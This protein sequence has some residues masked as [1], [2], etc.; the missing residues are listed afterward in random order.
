MRA[1]KFRK[2][3]SASVSACGVKAA[4]AKI[5]AASAAAKARNGAVPVMNLTYSNAECFL[6][7][8]YAGEWIDKLD[9]IKS[10]ID[11]RSV[12][13]N[14]GAY[15]LGRKTDELIVAAL[16]GATQE[17]VGTGVG[18]AD[19]DGLTKQKVLMAFEMLGAAD[20]P[21]DGQRFAVVG[22]KQW[23]ELLQIQE[24]AST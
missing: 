7:D 5:F 14:A 17:A 3:T 15:A 4:C 13:A 2:E 6:Q 19:T 1:G 8:Y 20:V 10:N 16:D 22:W 23:S 12:I 11:E 21:D 18:L 24:F 9:E